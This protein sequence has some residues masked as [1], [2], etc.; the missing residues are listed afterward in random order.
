M[1]GGYI[2]ILQNL[3]PSVAA[4][5]PPMDSKTQSKPFGRGIH[6]YFAEPDAECGCG[7]AANGVMLLR[8]AVIFI[9]Y[10]R[11]GLCPDH[12]ILRPVADGADI[13]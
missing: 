5:L 12:Q 4:A 10:I 13:L 8:F 7:T 2:F 1:V 6:I 11:N 3:T 9:Q